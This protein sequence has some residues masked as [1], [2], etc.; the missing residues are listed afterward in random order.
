MNE[1]LSEDLWIPRL[2]DKVDNPWD[3]K[4]EKEECGILFDFLVAICGTP[5]HEQLDKKKLIFKSIFESLNFC[6]SWYLPGFPYTIN[7]R[8]VLL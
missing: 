2:H 5:V 4:L 3:Q 1:F 7:N 8:Y 6:G